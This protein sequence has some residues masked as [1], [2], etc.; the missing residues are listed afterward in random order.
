MAK[1]SGKRA[2]RQRAARSAGARSAPAGGPRCRLQLG[3]L[4]CCAKDTCGC[5]MKRC[6]RRKF[7]IE[8]RQPTNAWGLARLC[9]CGP[10]RKS[11]GVGPAT[12]RARHLCPAG[13]ASPCS[14]IVG[15][16]HGARGPNLAHSWL[17]ASGHGRPACHAATCS[18]GGP[19]PRR[20]PFLEDAHVDGAEAEQTS[21][22]IS[23][24]LVEG[25]VADLCA[26]VKVT[27]ARAVLA[28]GRS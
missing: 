23:R 4:L 2:R 18:I 16:Q 6:L 20:E 15:A 22:E 1:G 13:S 28:R 17:Y 12:A 5:C 8:P 14:H 25:W 26:P 3:G 9:A 11:E 7:W 10:A 21:I 19:A 27:R 24:C